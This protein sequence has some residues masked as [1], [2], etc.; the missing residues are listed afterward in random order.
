[1]VSVRLIALGLVVLAVMAHAYDDDEMEEVEEMDE[2][3]LL[4]QLRGFLDQGETKQHLGQN[5]I[6]I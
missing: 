1:M 5:L 2:R 4:V 6:I 3:G